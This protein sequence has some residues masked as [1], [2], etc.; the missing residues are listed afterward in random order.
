MHPSK[1]AIP[2]DA[3]ETKKRMGEMGSFKINNT[4]PKNRIQ[5]LSYRK[6]SKTLLKYFIGLCRVGLKLS[7]YLA[8]IK[9]F[10]LFHLK[11]SGNAGS[12]YKI[13]GY[14]R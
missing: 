6:T 7:I 14:I 3:I 12:V 13:S 11:S 10:V 4:P 9:A 1:K 5:M 8:I 2:A